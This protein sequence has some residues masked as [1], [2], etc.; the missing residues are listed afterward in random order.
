MFDLDQ[1]IAEWRR[2]MLAAGVKTPATLE[3]LEGHLREDVEEQIRSG[4]GTR[5][6]FE[7]TVLRIG[8]PNML[9]NEFRKN[10][11]ATMT[12]NLTILLGILGIV[13][14]PAIFLPALAQHRDYGT[15]TRQMVIPVVLGTI[16]VL[17]GVG[18]AFYGS[19]MRRMKSC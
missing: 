9:Q 11:R 17:V 7:I 18:T 4:V 15:W 10:E 16:I 3:E 12:R 13:V 14:G 1:S 5:P 2:Q 8:Q 19:R 6:A